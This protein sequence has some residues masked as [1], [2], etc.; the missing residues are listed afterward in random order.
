MRDGEFVPID[1]DFDARECLVRR[2]IDQQRRVVS[3]VGNGKISGGRGRSVCPG[4]QRCERQ[5]CNG[6]SQNGDGF[7]GRASRRNEKNVREDY[8]ENFAGKNSDQRSTG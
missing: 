5:D 8:R 6:A 4:A 1:S 3:L 7:H 2:K